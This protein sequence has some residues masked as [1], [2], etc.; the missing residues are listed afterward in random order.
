MYPV[1]VVSRLTNYYS[2]RA[3]DQDDH[4]RRRTSGRLQISSDGRHLVDGVPFGRPR[5]RAPTGRPAVYIPPRK[6]VRLTYTQ[7]DGDESD[8]WPGA[9][10]DPPTLLLTDGKEHEDGDRPPNTQ[11]PGE[12]GDTDSDLDDTDFV[13]DDDLNDSST[14][15]SDE[16]QTDDEME[17][18]TRDNEDDEEEE[19]EVEGLDQ[20][21]RE[22][23]V[24][25]AVLNFVHD[26][27]N[28][29]RPISLDTLDKLTALRTTFPTAPVDILEKVL[30]ASQGDLRTTHNVLSEGFDPQ[31]SQDA[32]VTWKP[33]ASNL[34]LDPEQSQGSINSA[35]IAGLASGPSTRK[36][37][38]KEQSRVEVEDSD[39]E[40]EEDEGYNTSLWRRYGQ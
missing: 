17:E 11:I 16:E 8:L 12:P 2:I 24:E 31:M 39:N 35:P 21:A 25:N 29:A 26:A 32:I 40:D 23:A 13:D 14:E 36:R 28:P 33:G 3:L 37:K 30:E 34:G 6:R 7:E 4:R 15:S 9:E 1:S 27:P 18:D 19:P 38:L 10:H 20:E 5:L 22:L